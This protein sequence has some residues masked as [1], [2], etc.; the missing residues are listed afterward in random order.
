MSLPPTASHMPESGF[1]VAVFEDSWMQ[2]FEW[3]RDIG[4]TA[5]IL[6]DWP[7]DEARRFWAIPRLDHA[8]QYGVSRNDRGVPL[9]DG[10]FRR[11]RQTF[12]REGKISRILW[13]RTPAIGLPRDL[14]H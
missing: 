2:E 3:L 12:L 6:R 9:P 13:V 4:L 11:E 8:L 1:C 7:V 14:S 10:I 5:I